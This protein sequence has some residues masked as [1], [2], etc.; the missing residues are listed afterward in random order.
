MRHD[1]SQ[2]IASF[3]DLDCILARR[4]Q[5]ARSRR[6]LEQLSSVN[7]RSEP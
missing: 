4:R 6:A 1:S 3:A 5:M 7:H 2:F